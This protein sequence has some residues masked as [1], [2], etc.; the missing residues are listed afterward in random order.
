MTDS[1]TVAVIIVTY[2]SGQVLQR[3]LDCLRAQSRR[4]DLV[5]IVDNC[6][7]E[8][9]YLE[10]IPREP[11][12][13]LVRL[14]RNEGFCR[15]NNIGY[16]LARACNY[17]LFLN[18][19]AFLSERFL[20]DA[21]GWMERPDS[22]GVGCLGGTLLGYDVRAARPTGLVDSTG[23][24]QTRLGRWYDR[25][26]GEMASAALCAA[27]EEVPAICGAL[28]FCRTA[29]LA[30]CA[31][32]DGSVFDPGFFMYKEDIDLSLRMR[33]AG[34]KLVYLPSL[35]C[36]HGRGWQ[37]R[38]EAS[39]RARY[40]SARNEVR[41]ARRY[42]RRT[43]PYSLAKLAYVLALERICLRIRSTGAHEVTAALPTDP[44]RS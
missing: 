13:R 31:L 8:P 25:G 44:S 22:R 17:V 29:A 20:E 36:A 34:W 39:F 42:R 6:S 26:R 15:G 33:A 38:A 2:D 16:S 7:R 19:D 28:M 27:G 5:V 30:Q 3:C 40:L 43:L 11:P 23:I 24:F 4:P 21:L 10:E 35:T 12:F 32:R 9:S 41:V 14:S 37:G 18:P 1:V